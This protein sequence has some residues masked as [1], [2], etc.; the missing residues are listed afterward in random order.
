MNHFVYI[1][2]C[3]D[4]YLYTGITYNIEKRLREHKS[5]LSIITKNR[6]PIKLVYLER[7][8]NKIDAAKR[9]KEIK[10]WKRSKKENLIDNY[11]KQYVYPERE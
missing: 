5:G 6:L 3:K 1:I 10:G 4:K 9:E 2:E 11:L 8:N 7:F